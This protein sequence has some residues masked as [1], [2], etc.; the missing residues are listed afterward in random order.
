[1]GYIC[2]KPCRLMGNEY[3]A[4]NI[5]PTEVILPDKVKALADMGF[6]SDNPVPASAET[7]KTAAKRTKSST[8][9]AKAVI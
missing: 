1:M 5:I 8:G 3:F 2:L 4:G 9:S 6:I 7:K